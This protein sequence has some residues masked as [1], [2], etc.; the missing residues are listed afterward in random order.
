M[1]I[2]YLEIALKWFQLRKEYILPVAK[3]RLIKFTY[4]TFSG[5][6]FW[7]MSNGALPQLKKSPLI[8][9]LWLMPSSDLSPNSCVLWIISKFPWGNA[10]VCTHIG[11]YLPLRRGWC[12]EREWCVCHFHIK[13]PVFFT[14][15][16]FHAHPIA[17]MQDRIVIVEPVSTKTVMTVTMSTA[18]APMTGVK[19]CLYANSYNDVELA[20][21]IQVYWNWLRKF[22]SFRWF[23]NRDTTFRDFSLDI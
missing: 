15:K 1:H 10:F 18:N 8:E 9:S 20:G 21:I 13:H 23:H 19:K 2:K 5:W 11:N 14:C 3:L 6:K 12:W 17:N 16:F 7:E 22:I 4:D